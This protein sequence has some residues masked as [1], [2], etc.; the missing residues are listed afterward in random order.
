MIV[1]IGRLTDVIRQAVPKATGLS[2]D[3][4]AYEASSPVS[5]HVHEATGT[6]VR[7][8]YATYPTEAERST[9][10]ALVQ[11]HNDEPTEVEKLSA[12][13]VDVLAHVAIA[14][15]LSSQWASLPAAAQHRIQGYIDVV[16]SKALAVLGS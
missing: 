2:I 14:V 5:V 10:D 7:C 9:V 11:G 4:G 3:N 15:R 8:S 16:A 12:V 13:N 6:K 1:R